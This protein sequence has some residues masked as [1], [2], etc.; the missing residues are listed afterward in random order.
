MTRTIT[1]TQRVA[2]LCARAD[3]LASASS[4]MQS[5]LHDST[6]RC[7]ALLK[8]CN[9]LLV[10]TSIAR[11]RSEIYVLERQ[12]RALRAAVPRPGLD[13]SFFS[14]LS[15]DE[16]SLIIAH[17]SSDSPDDLLALALAC[18][19]LRRH[20]SAACA[21]LPSYAG[22]RYLCTRIP[23][24][25]W[26]SPSR[27]RWAVEEAGCPREKACEAAAREGCAL[28]PSAPSAK[29]QDA[30]ISQMCTARCAIS[31]AR[32]HLRS[33][34]TA[35]LERRRVP[36]GR[37]LGALH[38]LLTDGRCEWRPAFAV[39]A[40]TRGQLELIQWA[41]ASGYV[42]LA[43]YDDRTRSPS[44]YPLPRVFLNSYIC[45]FLNTQC[46]YEVDR[47]ACA[48]AVRCRLHETLTFLEPSGPSPPLPTLRVHVVRRHDRPHV[49]PTF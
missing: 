2:A 32:S 33:R 46:R 43:R 1:T 34:P 36:R 7:S 25:I 30:E 24:I 16:I 31:A 28:T 12:L 35:S 10:G 17:L 37:H 19:E 22:Q 6:Q 13:H 49:D 27:L 38:W 20:V 48:D 23:S 47:P 8:R 15:A 29:S 9:R 11:V 41:V 26:G 5:E 3:D 39:A 42:A 40:A 14:C 4:R 44:P 45:L 18:A 21:G